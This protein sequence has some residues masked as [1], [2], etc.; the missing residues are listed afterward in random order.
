MPV[1]GHFLEKF[2]EPLGSTNL[3]GFHYSNLKGT[4]G[5]GRNQVVGRAVMKMVQE[6]VSCA[7]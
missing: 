1:C 7:K 3:F 4:T 2:V 5:G 6:S